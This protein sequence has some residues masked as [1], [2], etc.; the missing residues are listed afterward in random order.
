LHLRLEVRDYLTR[1]KPL[2]GSG[3]SATGND[4]VALLGLRLTRRGS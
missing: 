2:E 3:T 1:F 4:V